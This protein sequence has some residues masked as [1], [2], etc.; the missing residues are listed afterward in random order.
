MG[1]KS[2]RGLNI[3]HL[4]ANTITDTGAASISEGLLDNY[5]LQKL[6]INNNKLTDK[7]VAS[8]CDTLAANPHLHELE[9][10]LNTGV[11]PR[12]EKRVADLLQRNQ[13]LRAITAD[14]FNAYDALKLAGFMKTIGF[15]EQGFFMKA[16]GAYNAIE[17]VKEAA[18]T[19]SGVFGASVE[20]LIALGFSIN[21]AN[22][23]RKFVCR[24]FKLKI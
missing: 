15:E 8:I 1:L 7:G 19:G 20:N 14:E 17:R 3:L 24:L 16:F 12:L 6:R 11:T 18:I 10:E 22:V 5:T 2:N 4:G 9:L 13:K 21:D 23:L